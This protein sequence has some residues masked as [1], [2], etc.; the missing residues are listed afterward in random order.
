MPLRHVVDACF[1]TGLEARIK[2][3]QQQLADLAILRDTLGDAA[4]KYQNARLRT[5][6]PECDGAKAL[7]ESARAVEKQRISEE[8]LVSRLQ[9]SHS[10]SGQDAG[11]TGFKGMEAHMSYIVER[12]PEL[13]PQLML[14]CRELRA[15]FPKVRK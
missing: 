6:E 4:R 11:A 12:L 7:L 3:H 14:A 1:A 2:G 5:L 15:R 13:S 9:D 10:V 8:E